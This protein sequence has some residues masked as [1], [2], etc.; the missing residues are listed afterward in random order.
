[1][2]SVA[3]QT[4]RGTAHAALDEIAS[5]H[6]AV[7]G[8]GPG[9]RYAT[10]EINHAYVVLLSSQFQRFCRDLHSEAVEH[11]V[12]AVNPS[13]VRPI[14]RA[15]FFEGRKLDRGNP[16]PANVGS[17]F[18][19]LGFSLWNVVQA[20]DRRN[21]RRRA[22]LERL[23]A[24]RNAIAHQDLDPAKLVPA[25]VRLQDVT[26]WRS[27]CNGLAVEFDRVV[28]AHLRSLVGVAPW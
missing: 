23:S 22:H 20:R 3:L 4:W 14:V 7:G 24:W 8:R 15:R 16:I 9:R 26:T 10:Q 11:L 6:R 21:A 19:R 18:G 28:R 25:R 2:T 27:A 5:A 1:M 13:S 12:N 17:D